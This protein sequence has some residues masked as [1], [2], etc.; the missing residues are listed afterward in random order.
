MA[1]IRG[2]A[3]YHLNAGSSPFSNGAN[4]DAS[5]DPSPLDA[6]RKQTSKIEDVLDQLSEPIKP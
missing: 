6:I 4:S 5:S 1:Q 2:T 3:G